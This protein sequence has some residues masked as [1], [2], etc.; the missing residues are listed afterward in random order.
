MP[1]RPL[2]Q[3]LRRWGFIVLAADFA[4]L[5][6]IGIWLTFTYEPDG[7]AIST[8]HNL[9]GVV[10]VLAA[11]VAATATVAD[12]ERSTAAV[13][14]AVVV[15]VLVAGMYLIGPLL[16]W[17]GLVVDGDLG[18]TTGALAALDGN[19]QAIQQGN[20]QF[21]ASE[22]RTYA[23][24]HILALPLAVVAMGA[25]GVWARRRNRYVPTRAA[26]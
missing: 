16:A 1:A 14:P 4:V 9:L 19:V 26:E 3:R 2:V 21:P 22:Y 10:A 11:L 24:L 13:V 6:V 5:A 17:E 20:E 25:A 15:L 18:R 12:A 7:G 23:W 8:V